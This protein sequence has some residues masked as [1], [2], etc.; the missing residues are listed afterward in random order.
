MELTL[1]IGKDLVDSLTS[2]LYT[3]ADKGKPGIL[4]IT[5]KGN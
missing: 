4:V 1:D 2:L 3:L 5:V